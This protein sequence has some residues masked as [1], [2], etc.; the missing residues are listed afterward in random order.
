[1][2]MIS[3]AQPVNTPSTS[4]PRLGLAGGALLVGR[5]QQSEDDFLQID[6]SSRSPVDLAS[7]KRALETVHQEACSLRRPQGGAQLARLLT[8]LDH[9]V[10]SKSPV[11]KYLGVE[12]ML[13]CSLESSA[14]RFPIRHPKL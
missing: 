13:S 3:A 11:P 12:R 6:K 14:E 7:K 9:G 5:K 4:S 2:D 10:E 8:R 1:M